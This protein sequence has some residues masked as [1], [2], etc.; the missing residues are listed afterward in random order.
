MGSEAFLGTKN[1]TWKSSLLSWGLVSIGICGTPVELGKEAATK[2][3][4]YFITL[5]LIASNAHQECVATTIS[6]CLF[7]DLRSSLLCLDPK[8]CV[9]TN[10]CWRCACFLPT[11]EGSANLSQPKH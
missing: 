2:A 8:V 4:Q 7:P 9:G 10:L 5:D 1:I 6:V 11:S 3:S